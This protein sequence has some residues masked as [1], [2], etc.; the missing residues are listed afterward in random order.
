MSDLQCAATF[1]LVP[2]T[3]A[4]GSLPDVRPVA[5]HAA[6]GAQEAAG[7]VAEW[8]GLPVRTLRAATPGE[9][10]AALDELADEYRGERVAVLAPGEL[11]AALARLVLP[12]GADALVVE[13]DADGHRWAR[14]PDVTRA[15]G[16]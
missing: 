11:V 16:R 2:A 3:T 7:A 13:V 4:L 15:T 14:W 6:P 12:E 1:V 10:V 5:L 8:L 9:L